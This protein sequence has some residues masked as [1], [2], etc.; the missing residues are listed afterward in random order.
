MYDSVQSTC[1]RP[2]TEI[3]LME[4]NGVLFFRNKRVLEWEELMELMCHSN[5]TRCQ[6]PSERLLDYVGQTIAWEPDGTAIR[7]A[8]ADSGKV[9]HKIEAQGDDPQIYIYEDIPII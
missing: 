7:E 6:F 2:P 1:D 8:G 4:T 3:V 5:E 9:R